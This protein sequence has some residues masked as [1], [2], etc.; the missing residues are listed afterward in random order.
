MFVGRPGD[1]TPHVH[2]AVQL[3]VAGRGELSLRTTARRRITAPG[4]AIA[5]GARHQIESSDDETILLYLDPCSSAGRAIGARWAEQPH[6]T[7][8][9]ASVAPV[10][11]ALESR[12]PAHALREPVLRAFGVLDRVAPAADAR[13]SQGIEWIEARISSGHLRAADVARA[14]GVSRGRLAVL[15]RKETGIPVS[16]FVLWARLQRAIRLVLQGSAL[17]EA[18]LDAGF[19]DASHLARTF[20]RMFGTTLGE[21]VARFGRVP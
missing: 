15:F 9:H 14:A 3:C 10:R 6:A 12:A 19:S 13:V 7:I 1:N 20:R 11:A 2:A 21:S 8:D 16:S 18:A 4:I 5:A 17:T